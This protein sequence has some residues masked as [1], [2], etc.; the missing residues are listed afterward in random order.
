M[1]WIEKEKSSNSHAERGVEVRVST[2]RSKPKKA[3]SFTFYNNA[4]L[5]VTKNEYIVCAMLGNRIYFKESNDLKGYKLSGKKNLKTISKVFRVGLLPEKTNG[6]YLLEFDHK[7]G[8]YYVD[9]IN[10]FYS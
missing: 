8:L 1:E 5:K 10:K 4:H 6:C 7:D 2:V 9:L 3:T